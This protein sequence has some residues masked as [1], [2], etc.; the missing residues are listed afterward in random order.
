MNNDITKDALPTIPEAIRAPSKAEYLFSVRASGYQIYRC[1]ADAN[2]TYNWVLKAPDATLYDDQGNLFG[3]HYA[4]PTWQSHDGSHI[5][6]QVEAKIPSPVDENAVDWLLVNIK[7]RGGNGVL[8]PVTYV[9]RVSTQG[10]K[11][12]V[13]P[14]NERQLG[15]EYRATY[16]TTYH[17]YG[18]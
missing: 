18:G 1:E 8:T 13:G 12:P 17:F 14:C 10:G 4:G 3:T 6:G 15:D 5:T 11:P 9:N 16:S 7:N 2:G